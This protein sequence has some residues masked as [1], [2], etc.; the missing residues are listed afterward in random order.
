[1]HFVPKFRFVC[2]FYA[3]MHVTQPT[4]DWFFFLF[5]LIISINLYVFLLCFY[6]YSL[7]VFV[8]KHVAICLK[9]DEILTRLYTIYIS[10]VIVAGKRHGCDLYIYNS[11]SFQIR[12]IWCVGNIK[13]I[14]PL[15]EKEK[16][17][18]TK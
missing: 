10:I 6:R 8:N 7:T 13:K 5:R 4:L 16:R 12:C 17:R 1:M 3:C 11:R 2:T 18:Y 9:I 14:R 15:K